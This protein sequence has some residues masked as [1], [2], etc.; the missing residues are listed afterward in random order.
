MSY[1]W[2]GN[3]TIFP[4]VKGK[5]IYILLLSSHIL[6]LSTA[7]QDGIKMENGPLMQI[8]IAVLSVMVQNISLCYSLS[9]TKFP[10]TCIVFVVPFTPFKQ[11]YWHLFVLF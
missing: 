1:K 2:K 8:N 7:L 4:V 11:N 6:G 10:S 3:T 5:H 9:L